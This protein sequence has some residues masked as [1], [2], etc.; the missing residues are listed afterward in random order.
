MVQPDAVEFFEDFNI[1]RGI[2]HAVVGP[3]DLAKLRYLLQD[4]A[5]EQLAARRERMDQV[6]R[7]ATER[8]VLVLGWSAFDKDGI[9]WL[10]GVE[11][12]ITAAM[13]DASLIQELAVLMCEF[14]RHRTEIMLDVCGM[15]MI[16][17]RRWYSSTNFWSPAFFRRFDLLHPVGL[18]AVRHEADIRLACVMTTGVMLLLDQLKEAGFDLLYFVD[19]VQDSVDLAVLSQCLEGKFAL[20]WGVNSGVTLAKGSPKEIR[21]AVH[22]AIRT[23]GVDGGFVFS[24]ADALFPD[25]PWRSVRALIDAWRDA[26]DY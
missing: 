5:H 10:R 18:V 22:A 12:A 17:Q 4:P 20:A 23:L 13:T 7:F 14:D 6:K 26:G 16:V 24:P 8:G 11:G 9:V 3:E 1:P 15:D 2:D 19:S 25:T 21:E